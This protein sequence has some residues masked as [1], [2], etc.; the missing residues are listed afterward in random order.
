[1]SVAVS[2]TLTVDL[3]GVDLGDHAFDT[4]S[5]RHFHATDRTGT[6]VLVRIPRYKSDGIR[7]LASY[8]F[9]LRIGQSMDVAGCLKPR[10]VLHVSGLSALVLEPFQGELLEALI[11]K[12]GMRIERLIDCSVDLARALDALHLQ[13][14]IHR[15][16]SPEAFLVASGDQ[17]AKFISLETAAILQHGAGTSGEDLAVNLHYAAPEMTGCM[18]VAV[19]YRADLYSL[20]TCLFRMATGRP[21]YEAG[22]G[23][24]LAYA[25]V[26]RP[27]P[28]LRAIRPELPSVFCD[29]VTRL[30]QKDPDERYDTAHGTLHDLSRCAEAF[31]SS[32]TVRAFELAQQDHITNFEFTDKPYGRAKEIGALLT[33]CN[34]HLMQG[35]RTVVTVSGP[36]G[37]GKTTVVDRLRVPLAVAGVQFVV[38]KFDQF[39]RD[40]P[41][42]AFA[43]AASNLVRLH[44]TQSSEEQDR[45]RSMYL[46]AIGEYGGLLTELV[47]ELTDL[48]GVQPDVPEVAPTEAQ[49]RF[50]AVVGRFFRVLATGKTP[51]VMFIDDLQWADPA[52]LAVIEALSEMPGLEHLM[53]ILGYRS[54]EIGPGHPA[55]RIVDVLEHNADHFE[56]VEIHPL[57]PQS[58]RELM[59]DT[60]RRQ[61]PDIDAVADLVH[62]ISSG[63]PFFVR[64]FLVSL[65]N[66]G[67][68]RFDQNKSDWQL[69]LDG[70]SNVSVPDSVAGMLTDRLADLPAETI[71]L[72]D[73]ASCIGNNFDLLTLSKVNEGGM[74]KMAVDLAPAIAGS[75]I[76]PL[77]SNQRLFE[78]MGAGG[79]G[80]DAGPALGNAHYRFRHDQ[81][82]LAVHARLNKH[83][84]AERHLKIGR[85]LLFSVD[86]TDRDNKAMEIFNH[87]EMGS[88]LITDPVE[89]VTVAR[90]GLQASKASRKGLAFETARAQLEAASIL[91]SLDAWQTHEDLKLEL[92]TGLA[93]CAFALTDGEAME[94]ASN[95][96][97]RHITDPVK[98]IPLQI[99]RIRY[100][101]TQNNFDDATNI[102]VSVAGTLG[103]PL[104]RRPSKTQVLLAAARAMIE[105][106]T[107]D[108]RDHKDLPEARDP[109]I[110]EAIEL[111]SSSCAIAYFSDP[112]LLPLLGITGT[113]L[114]IK[115]G[116]APRSP[117]CFA[118]Q[119]L[120]YCGPLNMI[121]RGYKFGELSLAT[122]KR[123]GGPNEARARF[124]FDSFVRHWKRPWP[125]VVSALY[126]TWAYNRDSGDHENAT[127]SGGVGISADFLSGRGVDTETR[128]SDLATYLIDCD[129]PHVRGAF[130]ALL[131]LMRALQ[132]PDL[133]AELQGDLF[134]YQFEI[135]NLE[136]AGNG[137]L[138]VQG[139][140]AGGILDFLAGRHERA[141]ARLALAA[142]H[143]EHITA[144]PLVPGLVFFRS[145]NAYRLVQKG[146][147]GKKMLRV[148]RRGK[149]R[150]QKWATF[151]P[152]NLSH[153]VSLLNAE[154]HIVR[155]APGKALIELHKA[156]ELAG[157]A[158]PLY[159]YLAH[160][161]RADL[162]AT[163][164]SQ[165]GAQ[166]AASAAVESAEAWGSIALANGARHR[167]NVSENASDFGT[168]AEAIDLAGFLDTVGAIATETDRET[169]L[170]RIMSNAISAANADSGLLVR[171]RPAMEPA[172]EIMTDRDGKSELSTKDLSYTNPL[173]VN[174]LQRCLETGEAVV[175][176]DPANDF[177]TGDKLGA[178]DTPKAI[179][180]VPIKL[181]AKTVGALCLTNFLT[182]HV[183]T[184]ARV[185]F[186]EALGSQAG[187]ALENA[188]LYG[189]VQS[190]LLRQ[191]EQT[192]ANQRFVPQ[193]LLQAL[194]ERSIIDV[195]L[196]NAVEQD[197]A[198][199]FADIRGFTSISREIGPEKT[200]QMINLYLSHVQ[201]G[202]AANGGFVGNYMGDGLL[203]LFPGRM[204]DAFHGAIA[205]S[206]GLD[207]Y[208][209]DRGEFPELHIG[210]GVNRGAVTLGMIGDEDHIQCGVLGDTVNV[211]ARIEGITKK[212]GARFIVSASCVSALSE[213]QRFLLRPIGR[214]S[215]RGHIDAL[216]L[217]ECLD[218]HPSDVRTRLRESL[219]TFSEAV[220][221]SE[222]GD[223]DAAAR[224]FESCDSNAGGDSVARRLADRCRNWTP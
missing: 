179:L 48:F 108:P 203:A 5:S 47:P 87:L 163:K 11:P 101:A 6:R 145:L 97:L 17:D 144:Q 113:R 191:T 56:A 205:M 127:Y 165:I 50:N 154:D 209:R 64:E 222:A 194:G 196:S 140:M 193:A 111:L 9:A 134:D 45:R 164:Q 19:D 128:F 42:L 68:I 103:V 2:N 43:E 38:G 8:R 29:I 180:C 189:E 3:P 121:E 23:T 107:R 70:I 62:G 16:V 34:D 15:D 37:I 188:R 109:K 172:I 100:L 28:D 195:E 119:A 153:R 138:L 192:K 133:P 83:L 174:A 96:I 59:A 10:D 52:S 204:D 102:A 89:R 148:A 20:G 122:G 32:G 207:G 41:Y 130:M 158:A 99:M 213:P 212:L 132:Q 54:D 176:N 73:T 63:N 55:R 31:H 214:F 110:R 210:I 93:E 224:L 24:P 152:P 98:T 75:L 14:V 57:M 49:I 197:M 160:E 126:N 125:E 18:E 159:A 161:R 115:H 104:P 27:V 217:F 167:F 157:D 208:N 105:Q 65:K 198:V 186:S 178:D 151:S 36:S 137:V 168:G 117:Y 156:A 199:V 116:L 12:D 136:A 60:L 221:M 82:R 155:R 39:Q 202:I 69:D 76:I 71:D 150:L 66:R 141:E 84:R 135:E 77:G 215:V 190:A 129:M 114:S 44:Q 30:L 1:M 4:T 35:R 78:A 91:L 92:E 181:R 90:L 53:M 118:V 166:L 120:M 74:A 106:G 61:G 173:L 139:A 72:L 162:L 187:F 218:V 219:S 51:L 169:L 94:A 25:H 88:E 21:P 26:T 80:D 40:K 171:T 216:E 95:E 124:V 143:E 112:N 46:D 201:A 79:Q 185:R 170:E 33:A 146:I 182:R 183:F 142:D 200:I 67:L 81:A 86:D 147:G 220:E 175:S 58:V 223:L 211:A 85:L 131:E 206:R 149:S 13:G 177:G 184:A 123:Y 7:T 22:A